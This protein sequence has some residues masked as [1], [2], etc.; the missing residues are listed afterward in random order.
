MS[1]AETF[2]LIEGDLGWGLRVDAASQISMLVVV[3]C[4]VLLKTRQACMK[5]W[6]P[7]ICWSARPRAAYRSEL[8]RACRLSGPE[9]S[10]T[11]RIFAL[12]TPAA[13]ARPRKCPLK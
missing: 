12:S 5:R 8:A 13:S 10:W 9:L 2:R 11:F 6:Q 7:C 1:D 3:R 4:E